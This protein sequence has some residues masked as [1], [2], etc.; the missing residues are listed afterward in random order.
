MKCSLLVNDTSVSTSINTQAKTK[1][2]I[3]RSAL[4]GAEVM[5]QAAPIVQTQNLFFDS[6]IRVKVRVIIK[7]SSLL[8]LWAVRVPG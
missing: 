1:K 8:R 2:N 6:W 5:N 3:I 4:F 7:L